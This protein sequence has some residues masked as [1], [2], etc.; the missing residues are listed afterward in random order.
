MTGQSQQKLVLTTCGNGLAF[1]YI[2]SLDPHNS[3]NP[4]CRVASH[5]ALV[6]SLHRM[7]Q[8]HK[9]EAVK[10]GRMWSGK[11]SCR[12]CHFHKIRRN[13]SWPESGMGEGVRV[14]K[15]PKQE[16]GGSWDAPRQEREIGNRRGLSLPLDSQQGIHLLTLVFLPRGWARILAAPFKDISQMFQLRLLQV[17]EITCKKRGGGKL[18]ASLLTPTP[19]GPL[20]S[21]GRTPP[22]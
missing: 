11:A 18:P 9:P 1:T 10:V 7:L 16:A 21:L 5:S 3:L 6:T 22:P 15:C 8:E 14:K 12:R 4:V 20:A 19:K 13:E 17:L 2:N